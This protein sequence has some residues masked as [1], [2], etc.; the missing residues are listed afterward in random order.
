VLGLAIGAALLS[1]GCSQ[2]KDRQGYLFDE[3]SGERVQPGVDNRESVTQTLGRPTFTGQFDQR[4][5][6]YVSRD[7]RQLAF[8]SPKPEAT[9]VLH[10][11]FDE[12]GNVASVQRSG[13]RRSPRSIRS[14]RKRRRSA[15]SAASSRSCSAISAPSAPRE[16]PAARPT[17]PNSGLAQRAMPPAAST[18][19][20]TR[21]DAF[22]VMAAICTGFAMP[23]RIGPI[24]ESPPSSRS[25]LAERFADWR[26]GHDQ[27]VGR[28]RE[29]AERVDA[30]HAGIERD[31][32][33]HLALI[34]EIHLPLVEHATASRMFSRNVPCGLPK[35]E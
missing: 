29:A 31:V 25:S 3:T 5:W 18:A 6:Y 34:F 17:T 15:A 20:V 4:D 10:I 23:T 16:S 26:P 35:L 30:L 27:H 24:T 7:T 22:A 13:W 9:T 8:A 14:T 33:R 32:R 11:R 1:A 21:S 28:A 2:I 19:S 12:A